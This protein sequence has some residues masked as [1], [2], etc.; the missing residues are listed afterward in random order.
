MDVAGYPMNSIAS[1]KFGEQK[2]Y[3]KFWSLV[4]NESKD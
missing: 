2:E 4:E 1:S 3:E